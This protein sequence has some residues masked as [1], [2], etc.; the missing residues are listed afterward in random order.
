MRQQL[1]D[2][3]SKTQEQNIVIDHSQ[4]GEQETKKILSDFRKFLVSKELEENVEDL[5][6]SDSIISP[7]K[8]SQ[9]WSWL[10]YRQLR[11]PPAPPAR[12]TPSS[13]PPARLSAALLSPAQRTP[14]SSPSKAHRGPSSGSPSPL[15]LNK[16]V[17]GFRSPAKLVSQEEES[18]VACSFSRL[19]EVEGLADIRPGE[20]L[21]YRLGFNVYP[22]V[23]TERQTWAYSDELTVL[24]PARQSPYGKFT[25]PY[26]F[27]KGDYP[28]TDSGDGDFEISGGYQ[29]TLVSP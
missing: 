25:Y 7:R 21:T 10:D 19:F 20:I 2:N 29:M 5:L 8:V 16:A 17:V 26:Q 11:D 9:L 1:E 13:Q 24:I 27:A 22:S 6:E 3:D 15:K 12:Q 23:I 14:P 28:L 18:L 4:T